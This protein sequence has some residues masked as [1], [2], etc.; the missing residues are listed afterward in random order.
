[1]FYTIR[2]AIILFLV[3]S[4]FLIF[5]TTTTAKEFSYTV[6]AG[7]RLGTIKCSLTVRLSK[8]ISAERLR[9]LAIELRDKETKKYDR[10]FITYYLP[11]MVVGA[12]AWATTHFNPNLKVS[13]LGLTEE[14]FQKESKLS[15][16]NTNN[17]GKIIGVWEDS[18]GSITISREKSGYVIIKKY[19]DG[20]GGKAKKLIRY[21]V[22]GRLAFKEKAY[23]DNYYV[24][25]SSGSLGVYD[26]LGLDVVMRSKKWLT[27]CS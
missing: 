14:E 22:K 17:P 12:G 7:D 20:S 1:M 4:I 10:T 13:I 6:I 11:G 26:S 16:E 18:L 19:I 8:R 23:P 2:N 3:F 5:S 25:D 9:K 21:K 24:I 15:K 27:D